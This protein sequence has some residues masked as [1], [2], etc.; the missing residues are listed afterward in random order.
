[1][2]VTR[3]AWF[4]VVVL[5]GCSGDTPPD[6][7]ANPAGPRCSKQLYDL[8]AQEHDCDS[9]ICFPIGGTQICTQGC[10]PGAPCPDQNG[11]PVTCDTDGRCAPAAPNMCHL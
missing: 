10:G 8:C 2:A 1:V 11:Q 7:D 9:N 4:L 5:A 3:L 6:V